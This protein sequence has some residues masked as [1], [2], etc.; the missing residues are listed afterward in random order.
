MGFNTPPP[1]LSK[2]VQSQ[3]LSQFPQPFDKRSYW[4]MI[5]ITLSRRFLLKHT[6][7]GLQSGFRKILTKVLTENRNNRQKH[8]LIL[9]NVFKITSWR[10]KIPVFSSF[11]QNLASSVCDS[12]FGFTTL[13]TKH[14]FNPFFEFMEP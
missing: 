6:K 1:Y 4:T 5:K 2:A 11:K 7:W 14:V 9:T 12:L 13:S 8:R 3:L 10:P